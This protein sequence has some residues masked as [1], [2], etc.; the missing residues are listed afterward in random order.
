[1]K[2]VAIGAAVVGGLGLGAIAVSKGMNVKVISKGS[3]YATDALKKA[4]AKWS[5]HPDLA[6]RGILTRRI[7]PAATKRHFNSQSKTMASLYK[8]QASTHEKRVISRY[9][10]EQFKKGSK[11]PYYSITRKS[12]YADGTIENKTS[13]LVNRPKYKSKKKQ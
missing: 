1:M 4:N 5:P 3:N 13:A 10:T 11:K 6:S 12:E 7:D 2:K 9:K 8:P